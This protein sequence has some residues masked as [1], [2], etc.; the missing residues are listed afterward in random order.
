[1]TDPLLRQ[2]RRAV[3][4]I[5]LAVLIAV[6]VGWA[7]TTPAPATSQPAQAAPSSAQ[8]AATPMPETGPEQPIPFSHKIHAGTAGLSCEFCHT[9]SKSGETLAIPQATACMQ[10]HTSI[11]TNNP[12]VQKVAGFAKAG[13]TIPWVRIYQ[14]P[15]FVTF[16]HKT[17]LDHGNTCQEC[18][19][20]VAQ[21]DRLFM[22][23]DISMAGCMNCHRIK[24]ASVECDTCHELEQ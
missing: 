6:S 20:P 9:L 12:D 18:H 24:K 10:C 19:G 21:R 2:R 11:A 5:G 15:S 17:H 7:Q 22:E 13:R 14:L 3:S 8:A 16:S 23:S 1:M 4:L